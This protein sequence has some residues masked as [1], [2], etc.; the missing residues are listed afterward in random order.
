MTSKMLNGDECGSHG[1]RKTDIN[2]ICNKSS[3][4]VIK[5]IT[6]PETCS[7]EVN[8]ETPLACEDLSLGYTM[9]VYP[10]LSTD[11]KS[12]WN[13]IYSDFKNGI[14]TEKVVIFFNF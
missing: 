7:Y 4:S 12:E 6:E 11:L 8:L 5:N 13:S 9:H 1:H 10:V 2:F 14:I 3:N